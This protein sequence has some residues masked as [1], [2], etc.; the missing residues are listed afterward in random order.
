[1]TTSLAMRNAMPTTPSQLLAAVIEVYQRYISPRKGFCCAYRVKR[2]RS[3]CSE[4]ARKAVLR[5]GIFRIIPL[6]RRRFDKCATAAH[7]AGAASVL[8]YERAK[9]KPK[10]KNSPSCDLSPGDC[11]P[12]AA[13]LEGVVDIGC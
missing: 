5:H 10:A 7:A 6:L 8:D 3:S 11:S 13:C 2:R 1:M 12:D 9:T 4:F